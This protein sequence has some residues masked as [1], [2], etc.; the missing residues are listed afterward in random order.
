MYVL[1]VISTFKES[2]KDLRYLSFFHYYDYTAAM[3]DNKLDSQAIWVFLGV[4]LVATVLGALWFMRRD[5][6]V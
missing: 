6:A 5:V 2:L 3:L 1:N 4:S